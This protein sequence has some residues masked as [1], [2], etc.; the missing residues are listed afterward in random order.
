[1]APCCGA[2]NSCL[3]SIAIVAAARIRAA[4]PMS[5]GVFESDRQP[6]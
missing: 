1:L 5:I 4:P 2:F 6:R 3:V